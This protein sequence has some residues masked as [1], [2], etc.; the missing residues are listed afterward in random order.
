MKAYFRAVHGPTDWEWINSQVPILQV[1]DTCGIVMVDLD[2]N[3]R[4]AACVLDN[5]TDNS[6]QAHFMV[7]NAAALKHGMLQECFDY[8]F[9]ELSVKYVYGLVPG[10]NEKAIKFNQ[11]L[12]FTELVRLP[13]AF[14][15]GVDYVLMELK[16]ANCNYLP[17]LTPGDNTDGQKIR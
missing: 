16:K 4:V 7:T 9:N 1:E 14:K 17:P 10:D 11:H 15:H 12:G 8:I 6:V 2:K 13:E 3:E 5:I